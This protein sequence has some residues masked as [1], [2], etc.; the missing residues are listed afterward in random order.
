MTEKYNPLEN[1]ADHHHLISNLRGEKRIT[2]GSVFFKTET[3]LDLLTVDLVGRFICLSVLSYL[4]RGFCRSTIDIKRTQ[5]D[6]FGFNFE[7]VDK[8]IIDKGI[9]KSVPLPITLQPNSASLSGFCVGLVSIEDNKSAQ[10]ELKKN[11][12]FYKS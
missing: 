7:I 6:S 9:Y 12:P 4:P 5:R 8:E 2:E 1:Y 3:P 10:Q 11:N